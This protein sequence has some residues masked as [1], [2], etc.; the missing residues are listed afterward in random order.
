MSCIQFIF[1]LFLFYFIVIFCV[2]SSSCTYFNN[3]FISYF[4]IEREFV[5]SIYFIVRHFALFLS[6]HSYPLNLY[7]SWFRARKHDMK[8]HDLSLDAVVVIIVV[9]I[10]D[11]GA[12]DD[13]VFIVSANIYISKHKSKAAQDNFVDVV[14]VFLFTHKKKEKNEICFCF[15]QFHSML[16]SHTYACKSHCFVWCFILIYMR[17]KKSETGNF[18]NVTVFNLKW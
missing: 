10:T 4:L 11:P 8:S 12:A 9:D 16:L 1:I 17:A 5:F 3:S 13:V 7:I 6:G 2:V 14:L 18:S 15:W